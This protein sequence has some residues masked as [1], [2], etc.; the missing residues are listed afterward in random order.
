MGE[1]VR[2][3]AHAAAPIQR[4][5]NVTENRRSGFVLL[6]KSIKDATFYRNLE[7]KSLWLHLL[8]EVQHERTVDTFNG[9]RVTLNR[10]QLVGSARSL[11]EACGVS[12]DSARRSL[13]AF[14]RDGMIT[15]T[16]KQGTKGYTLITV[17]NYDPY[18]RGV[19]EHDCAELGAEF[20]A[21]SDMGLQVVSQSDCAEL[22]AEFHAEALNNINNKTSKDLKDSSSQLASATF[23]QQGEQLITDEPVSAEPATEPKTRVIPEAAI[24]TPSGKAWGTAEDLQTAQWMFARVQRI[25]PTALEPNWPQWANVIRLMRELDLRSHS[26]IC[27]LYDWVSRDPFWCANV[28]SPQKLRQKWD[29]LTAKR[30]AAPLHN[31]RPLGNLAAAQQHAQAIMAN[32]GVGY[33]DNTIL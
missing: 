23:D 5:C 13:E 12:E 16:S 9:N 33:D 17:L 22:G 14:E 11:G 18:Q 25:N 20:E 30:N 6:Y 29:Q 7:R 28:L 31:K 8:I 4:G 27:E 2:L 26:D 10:G 32:S 21:A 19:S 24:Q 15:R 3:A 1:V